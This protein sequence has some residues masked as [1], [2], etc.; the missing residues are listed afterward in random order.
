MERPE[1]LLQPQDTSTGLYRPPSPI[2]T[3]KKRKM[4]T[5]P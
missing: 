4:E 3:P 1:T 5:I 2:A